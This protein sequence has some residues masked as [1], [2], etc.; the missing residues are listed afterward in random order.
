MVSEKILEVFTPVLNKRNVKKYLNLLKKHH[1]ESYEHS[2]RV[3][4]L[5]IY[6][7]FE[8]SLPIKKI[9]LL[10]YAGLLHDI[11]KLHVSLS[12]LLKK[13]PLTEEEIKKVKEHPRQ[14]Y[15]LLKDSELKKVRE[16]II[17]HHEYCNLSYP[18]NGEDRRRKKRSDRR[19]GNDF[20]ELAQ[21]LSVA[22]M[23]DAL[24]HMRSYHEPLGCEEIRKIMDKQFRGKK[25][26]IRQ[27]I[28][29]CLIDNPSQINKSK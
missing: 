29:K 11:G 16:I 12:I 24:S 18:R 7:G 20:G 25:S 28:T 19:N 23:Y 2:L 27:V 8:N 15:L 14:G 1:R 9:K 3:G 6:L 4:L 17:S 5:C 10:C 21:I 26:Y 13:S 22:D